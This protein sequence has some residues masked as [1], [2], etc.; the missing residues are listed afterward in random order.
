[1]NDELT[2][3]SKFSNGTNEKYNEPK[4]YFKWK[5]EH[6]NE[7]YRLIAIQRHHYPKR[8]L[9]YFIQVMSLQC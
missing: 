6:N 5:D 4:T 8:L 7:L 1:M 3:L 9:K 2:N